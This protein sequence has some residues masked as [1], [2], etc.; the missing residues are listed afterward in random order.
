MNFEKYVK[1]PVEI[2]ACQWSGDS[3]EGVDL[4]NFIRERTG[5][6]GTFFHS[7]PWAGAA[8]HIKTLEG[9]MKAS[10]GDFIIRGVNG[11]FYPCKPD[12]FAKSYT[13][14]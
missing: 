5:D 11:E 4:A 6:N 2:V 7:D 1:N 12:I 14:V 3:S 9:T 13:K 8:I 10:P